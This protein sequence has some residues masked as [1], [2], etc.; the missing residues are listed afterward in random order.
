MTLPP[1]YD[2]VK[3]DDPHF[4]QML[5]LIV[6]TNENLNIVGP[7]GT[8]KSLGIRLASELL[9]G[10]VALCST[11]GISAVN[12]SVE[13]L[14]ASTLHSFFRM[15]PQAYYDPESLKTEGSV[16]QIIANLDV[17]IID[18]SSMMSSHFFDTLVKTILLY[19]PRLPRIILFSDILQLAPVINLSDPELGDFYRREYKNQVMFFNSFAFKEYGFKTIHLNKLYRQNGNDFQIVLNNMRQELHS[20]LDLD[21]VN[22]FVKPIDVYNQEH[23]LYMY[24]ATTNKQ[25]DEINKKYLELF[26][27]TPKNYFSRITGQ[28]DKSRLA[29]LEE[30][31]TLKPGMQIMCVKNNSKEGYQ[32]GSIGKVLTCGSNYVTAKLGNGKIVSVQREEWV[33]D[34]H[35]MEEKK[36]KT[37]EVGKFNQIGCKASRSLTAHKSQGQ[38]LE[39]VYFD[40]GNWVFADSLVY[41]ALSRLKDI[42]NLGLKRKLRMNDIRA[43][44]ESLEFLSKI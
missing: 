17:L 40:P 31:V 41:V 9:Q 43:N 25:V 1:E 4:V 36:L 35:Y 29:A 15:K 2:W 34:E 42:N 28:F 18:E 19:R 16:F 24:I 14:K 21:Y 3:M 23:E 30:V 10:N 27:G 5:D 12:I 8:G 38:T 33:Q 32:N 44:K 13:G 39:A 7:A 6:N 22:Q 26:D 37:R 11:T 20:Q